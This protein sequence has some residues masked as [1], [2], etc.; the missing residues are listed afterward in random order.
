[1][2]ALV[3]KTMD[4][5]SYLKKHES[6]PRL[7]FILGRVRRAAHLTRTADAPPFALA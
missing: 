3:E 7:R 1:M 6:K 2:N 5:A 4:I